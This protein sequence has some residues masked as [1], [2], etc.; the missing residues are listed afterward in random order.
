MKTNNQELN[1]PKEGL[2][3]IG[4]Y[5]KCVTDSQI[6]PMLESYQ[7]NETHKREIERF[8]KGIIQALEDI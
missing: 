7:P 5:L 4:A 3:Q 8:H 6:K 2:E 1:N